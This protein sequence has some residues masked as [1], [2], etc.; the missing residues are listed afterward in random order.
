MNYFL[1]RFK[2]L[3]AEALLQKRALG[4]ELA[5]EAHEAIE[6]IFAERNEYLPP[7]PTKPVVVDVTSDAKRTSGLVRLLIMFLLLSIGIGASN[8][9]SQSWIGIVITICMVIYWVVDWIRRQSLSEEERIG[10]ELQK[11]ADDDGLTELMTASA[12][13]DLNRAREL[14]NFQPSEINRKSLIGSTAL[15]YAARN[16]HVE[17]VDLLLQF[18]ADVSIKSHKGSTALFIAQKFGHEAVISSIESKSTR[19][20]VES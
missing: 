5:D 16:N 13:G 8:V 17:V 19:R 11:Q 9:L 18:G 6:A 14:L 20:N 15:M 12:N 2:D 7:R 4:D 10:E 3:S 1:E